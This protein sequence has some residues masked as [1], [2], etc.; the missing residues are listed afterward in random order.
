ML[1]TDAPVQAQHP[2]TA[3]Q[4]SCA[5][6]KVPSLPACLEGI[7]TGPGAQAKHSCLASKNTQLICTHCC[8][9]AA[10]TSRTHALHEGLLHRSAC[11]LLAGCTTQI[12]AGAMMTRTQAP[13]PP[14]PPDIT[15][16]WLTG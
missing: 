13:P 8:F 16:G 15:S 1:H 10:H 14:P 7:I 12:S 9:D 5:C 4:F 11:M 2:H 3:Q 6:P